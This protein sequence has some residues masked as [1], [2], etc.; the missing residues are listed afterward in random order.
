MAAQWNN[1]NWTPQQHNHHEG[2]P[3]SYGQHSSPTSMRHHRPPHH[4]ERRHFEG[5]RSRSYYQSSPYPGQGTAE[6]KPHPQP[7]QQ[8]VPTNPYFQFINA[9]TPEQIPAR[10]FEI[11]RT[12]TVMAECVTGVSGCIL[13]WKP[14]TDVVL[15]IRAMTDAYCHRGTSPQSKLAITYIFND[16]VQKDPPTFAEPGLRYFFQVIAPLVSYLPANIQASHCRVLDVLR[17]R[18]VYTKEQTHPVRRT[19]TV[20]RSVDAD[21]AAAIS[22]PSNPCAE[23]ELENESALKGKIF[24]TIRATRAFCSD[25]RT[26]DAAIVWANS[27]LTA[28]G[29]S[30]TSTHDAF[31]H[32]DIESRRAL[33]AAVSRALTFVALELELLQY[34]IV[35]WC[36]CVEENQL[37]L[38]RLANFLTKELNGQQSKGGGNPAASL[39]ASPPTAQQAPPP[40]PLSE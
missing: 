30:Q 37:R 38:T 3:S 29:G 8:Q 23:L 20:D 19:F 24:A 6:S 1:T 11:C 7:Q 9:T 15:V 39:S 34:F 5:G 4:E 35:D 18:G 31:Q 2:G 33:Q 10:V 13:A 25:P 28:A 12:A 26:A 21:L 36:V 14:H 17:D 27:L 40:S 16:L 32:L 22:A